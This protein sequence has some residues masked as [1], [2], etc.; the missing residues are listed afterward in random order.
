M[1]YTL[2]ETT[3]IS[4]LY[5]D[6]CD[7][8]DYLA[9]ACCGAVAGLVDILFVGAPTDS[10]LIGWTDKQTDE[11]I[12][13]FARLS[14]WK[15][16]EGY[17]NSVA[18]AIR[19]LE[20]VF[21]VNYDQATGEAANNVFDMS[22]KNHHMKSLSHS[23]SI[24]G[25]VFSVL[26]QFRSTSSF[27]DHGRLITMNTDTFELEG[28]N[29][30]AK[31]FCGMG[32]WFGH[33]M[34]D[35]GGSSGANSRGSGVVIPFYELLGMCNFGKFGD[36]KQGAMTLADLA[37]KAFEEG[38]DLRFGAAQS[39]PVIL[40]EVL[41]RFVWSI[42]RV[43]A[44]KYPLN[45]CV[46]KETHK[47]LRAMLLCSSGTLCFMDG[48]DAVIRSGGNWLNFFLRLNLPAWYRLIQLSLKELCIRL[49]TAIQNMQKTNIYI[50]TNAALGEYL[51]ELA[52]Y[53]VEKF[54]EEVELSNTISE[55]ID[56]D[57]SE[58]EL[59][60]RLMDI[61]ERYDLNKPWSGNFDEFMCNEELRLEFK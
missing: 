59:N 1:T 50:Q 34:S 60:V 32:N 33:I 39:V 58:A 3:A 54:R 36:Y 14:G 42:R 26:D 12:M 2:D 15:P 8:Y 24:V 49:R 40:S 13:R 5:D 18:S 21:K 7:R 44:K 6:S 19:R 25:L 56:K 61:F 20:K 51:K 45:E 31:L 43:F 27:L 37:T 11:F 17:E 48:A 30:I 35:I 38:Y 55:L 57:M 29:F 28:G 53:D 9:A 47:D 41:V 10:K 23:P 52:K 16:K 46:P 22:T 4:I